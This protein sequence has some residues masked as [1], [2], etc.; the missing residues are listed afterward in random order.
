MQAQ[1]HQVRVVVSLWDEKSFS[2]LEQCRSE[3]SFSC[4]FDGAYD[5]SDGRQ[6]DFPVNFPAPE[7]GVLQGMRQ[8]SNVA[9]EDV[10]LVIASSVPSMLQPH[11][12]DSLLPSTDVEEVHL[13]IVRDFFNTDACLQAAVK[14]MRRH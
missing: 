7:Q 11:S 10:L 6:F 9:A 14:L 8:A 1:S 13:C 2:W 12:V 3:G 5:A 4:A